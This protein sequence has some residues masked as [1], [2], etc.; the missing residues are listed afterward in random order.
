MAK[1]GY[2]AIYIK[3][4]N[5]KERVKLVSQYE[6]EKKKVDVLSSSEILVI[7]NYSLEHGYRR[8]DD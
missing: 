6:R 3:C 1:R 4:K 7:E 5:F 2:T 8:E